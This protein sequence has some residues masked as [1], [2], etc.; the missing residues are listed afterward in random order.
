MDAI[1]PRYAALE[2]AGAIGAIHTLDR[3]HWVIVAS[4]H[5]RSSL[6]GQLL[7]F[8][9]AHYLPINFKSQHGGIEPGIGHAVAPAQ[10]FEHMPGATIAI[11]ILWQ[12]LWPSQRDC[13]QGHKVFASLS[14][15]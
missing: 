6:A 15:C 1:E 12:H 11:G 9:I 14:F 7:G 3:E 8:G 13:M 4:R 5:A 10:H 2:C